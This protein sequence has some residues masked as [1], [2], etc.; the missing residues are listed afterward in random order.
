MNDSGFPSY[1]GVQKDGRSLN[2]SNY[3][4]KIIE[5]SH[6]LTGKAY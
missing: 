4:V 5:D 3:H 1:I 6:Y 2:S